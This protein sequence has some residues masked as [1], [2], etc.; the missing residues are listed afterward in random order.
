MWDI[1]LILEAANIAVLLWNL[2]FMICLVAERRKN[3]D[4]P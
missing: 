3:N 2:L 4:I 1:H